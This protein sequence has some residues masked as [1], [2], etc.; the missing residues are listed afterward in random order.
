MKILVDTLPKKAYE[1]LF[2][3]DGRCSFCHMRLSREKG[4]DDD[5]CVHDKADL[6]RKRTPTYEG[7]IPCPY[8]V[9][10]HYIG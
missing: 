2:Y 7:V 5:L 8:L 3:K 6:I 9:E 1:C 10:H 4:I